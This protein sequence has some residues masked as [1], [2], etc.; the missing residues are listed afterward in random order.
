[1]RGFMVKA[2]IRDVIFAR[3]ER[4]I[5]RNVRERE[6]LRYRRRLCVNVMR[7]WRCGGGAAMICGRGL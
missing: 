4:M 7:A 6:I 1:M 3:E 5:W 2:A